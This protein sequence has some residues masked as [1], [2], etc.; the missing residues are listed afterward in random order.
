MK[1]LDDHEASDEIQRWVTEALDEIE[2][3]VNEATGLLEDIRGVD[4]LSNVGEALTVLK[5]LSTELY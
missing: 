2:V 3:Q 5:E 1:G 4:D